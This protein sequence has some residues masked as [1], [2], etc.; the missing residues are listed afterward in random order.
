MKN[1]GIIAIALAI[2]HAFKAYQRK[3]IVY[4]IGGSTM[5]LFGTANA[6]HQRA[7]AQ[8]LPQFFTLG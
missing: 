6:K 1:A 4:T 2:V 8:M 5:C 7:G 3:V